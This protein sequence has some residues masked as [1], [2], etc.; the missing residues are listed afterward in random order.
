MNSSNGLSIF[1]FYSWQCNPSHLRHDSL[2][3]ATRASIKL[4][5]QPCSKLLPGSPNFSV[6]TDYFHIISLKRKIRAVKQRYELVQLSL[7]MQML[8]LFQIQYRLTVMLHYETGFAIVRIHQ[9][10]KNNFDLK[11][12][13]VKSFTSEGRYYHVFLGNCNLMNI[14]SKFVNMGPSKSSLGS[15]NASPPEQASHYLDYRCS[16]DSSSNSSCL[17]CDGTSLIRQ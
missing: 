16:I 14:S 4:R 5:Y 12:K 13:Y 8:I 11:K 9:I 2:N 15:G 1:H 3:T 7:A 17:N 6:L 10:V